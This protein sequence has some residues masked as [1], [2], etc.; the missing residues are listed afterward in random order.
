[1]QAANR[2]QRPGKHDLG[3]TGL[4]LAAET[5]T[6]RLRRVVGVSAAQSNMSILQTWM[7]DHSSTEQ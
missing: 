3:Y 1:M 4:R 2:V 7:T 5:P 6:F